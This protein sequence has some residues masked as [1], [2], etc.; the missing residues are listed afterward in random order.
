M[1]MQYLLPLVIAAVCA[2]PLSGAAQSATAAVAQTTAAAHVAGVWQWRLPVNNAPL[3][4]EALVLQSPRTIE[5]RA[6]AGGGP[7]AVSAL[8]LRG[9]HI[10]FTLTYEQFG[11]PVTLGFSGRVQ[12]EEMGGTVQVSVGE[13]GTLEW[14]ATRTERGTI[15]PE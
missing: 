12:G 3:A 13:E 14:T 9:D 1:N 5:L 11:Q 4:L 15:R 2:Q 8:S 6:K 10:G 7:A